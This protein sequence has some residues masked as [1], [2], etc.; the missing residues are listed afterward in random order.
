MSANRSG[1]AEKLA[2]RPITNSNRVYIRHL[3]RRDRAGLI[4]LANSSQDMHQPWIDSPVDSKMF[5]A[6]WRRSRD[7]QFRSLVC[8]HLF[9]DEIVGL[10]NMFDILR[11]NFLSAN[12]GY[13]VSAAHAGQ[14]YMTEALNLVVDYSFDNL[15]LHRLEANIQPQNLKS[16]N[17]VQR[18][19][20]SLEGY[21][22]KFLWIDG[23]WKDHER[24]ALL[25]KRSGF[26]A[27]RYWR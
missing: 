19:G 10:I 1:N 3:R 25:D 23:S 21:A 6:L 7:K 8:C 27:R 12:I 13:Y 15:G 11:G 2:L 14:G 26:I 22:P 16:R 24:W 18:C 9:T 17:L 4:A 5:K 20:F